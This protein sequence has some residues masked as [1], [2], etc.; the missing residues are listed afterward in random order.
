LVG[1]WPNGTSGGSEK[2]MSQ[3]RERSVSEPRGLVLALRPLVS[4]RSRERRLKEWYSRRRRNMQKHLVERTLSVLESRRETGGDRSDM[5][6]AEEHRKR[7]ASWFSTT[8]SDGSCNQSPMQALRQGA[9]QSEGHLRP[10]SKPWVQIG[11]RGT[12]V[13]QLCGPCAR[14]GVQHQARRGGTEAGCW[15]T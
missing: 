15:A 9:G 11:K 12:A 6:N 7:T 10:K 4:A 3:T 1:A 2:K 5:E 13:V 8:S 14:M